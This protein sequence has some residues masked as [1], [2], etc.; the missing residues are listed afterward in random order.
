[1]STLIIIRDYRWDKGNKG[2]YYNETGISLSKIQHCFT[3]E[4][5][6]SLCSD[7]SHAMEISIYYNEI[8][9]TLKI[10]LIYIFLK[11]LNLP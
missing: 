1:M 3:C 10:V 8:V 7:T 11:Y 6:D 9:H 2:G 5:S 4:M